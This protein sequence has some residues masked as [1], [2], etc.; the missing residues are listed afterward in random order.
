MIGGTYYDYALDVAIGCGSH[1]Y[2][3]GS[4]QSEDFPAGNRESIA[5]TGNMNFIV[6][7]D[8][9]TLTMIADWIEKAIA[10]KR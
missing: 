10:R 9:E 1:A 5:F 7:F 2:V 8:P 3:S 4:T 6:R